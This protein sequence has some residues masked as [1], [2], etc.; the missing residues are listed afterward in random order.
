MASIVIIPLSM[1]KLQKGFFTY[2]AVSRVALANV[3]VVRQSAFPALREPMTEALSTKQGKRLV[4]RGMAA[5]T[6]GL[7]VLELSLIH[8]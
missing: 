3:N 8:I 7:G 4:V 6:L 5:K 2:S 1:R